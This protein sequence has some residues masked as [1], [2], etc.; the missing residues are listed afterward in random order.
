MPRGQNGVIPDHGTLSRYKNHGC[1]CDPCRRANRLYDKVR[2]Y[3]GTPRLVDSTGTRR[4][5]QALQAI[6]WST[7]RLAAEL[8]VCQQRITHYTSGDT[9]NRK[10]ANRVAA[11]FDRL[12]MHPVDD[13]VPGAIRTKRNAARNGYPPPLAFDDIDDP[14]EKPRKSVLHKAGRHNADIDEWLFLV[15][16]GESPERAAE[17][18]GVDIRAIDR[19]AWRKG[20]KDVLTLAREASNRLRYELE[21]KSA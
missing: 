3:E 9:V 17:R 20:R 8:G 7:T 10:T 12:S 21:R 18:L 5:I 1:I 15:R 2:K 11:L 6:G 4:R 13:S 14:N 16:G 19:A